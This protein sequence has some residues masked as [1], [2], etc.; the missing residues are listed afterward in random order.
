MTDM[1]SVFPNIS[2]ENP[3]MHVLLKPIDDILTRRRED[4]NADWPTSVREIYAELE[5]L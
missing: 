2:I 4:G 5:R 3:A 1:K